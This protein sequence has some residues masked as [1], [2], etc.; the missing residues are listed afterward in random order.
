MVSISG[1]GTGIGVLSPDYMHRAKTHKKKSHC[2][3]KPTLSH[4]ATGVGV[5]APSKKKVRFSKG[6]NKWMAALRRW[7][8]SHNKGSWCIP[9]KGSSDYEAVRKMM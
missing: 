4:G 7:N 3:P 9:K 8:G 2:P 1:G 6:P 5:L